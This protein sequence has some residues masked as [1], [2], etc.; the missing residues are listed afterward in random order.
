MCNRSFVWVRTSTRQELA[1]LAHDPLKCATDRPY[2]ITQHERAAP[3]GESDSRQ[4]ER[5]A[6]S[7]LPGR[8]RRAQS[9]PRS[10]H[11]SHRYLHAESC[12]QQISALSPSTQSDDWLS[13]RVHEA[14]PLA[15]RGKPTYR[16]DANKRRASPVLPLPLHLPPTQPSTLAHATRV[17]MHEHSC[18]CVGEG[19]GRRRARRHTKGRRMAAHSLRWMLCA[20]WY[21][22][23]N[24]QEKTFDTAYDAPEVEPSEV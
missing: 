5:Q 9:P 16:D 24:V 21:M 17:C 6:G 10:R 15:A 12:V 23:C 3:Q 18:S 8:T 1:T 19:R 2:V 13:I 20:A 11:G 4:T 7:A 22:L 14:A